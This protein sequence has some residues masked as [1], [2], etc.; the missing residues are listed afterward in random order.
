MFHSQSTKG[1][2]MQEKR[3]FPRLNTSSVIVSWRKIKTLDN[4]S[5]TKDISGGG[6]CLMIEEK[7]S[8]AVGDALQ[9]EFSLPSK[10]IIHSKGQVVWLDEFAIGDINAQSRFEV[11]IEFIDISDKDREVIKQYVF[12][13]LPKK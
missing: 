10:E 7:D 3:R 8:L 4:L 9:L 11:G 2:E 6:I 13:H 5:K 12:L 1:A